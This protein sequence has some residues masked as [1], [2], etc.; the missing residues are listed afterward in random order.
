M[1]LVGVS[2]GVATGKSSVSRALAA[3]AVPVVDA[4]A[5]ARDVVAP[6]TPLLAR[7]LAAFP[8]DARTLPDGSLDRRALG[9]AVFADAGKRR[10]L[11]ALLHPAIARELVSRLRAAFASG[12]H[13]VALDAPLLY[14]SRSLLRLCDATCVVACSPDTQL[15]RL[16]ARDPDLSE[17]DARRRIAA[18][19]P[20]ADKVRQA[21]YVVDNNGSEEEMMQ[22]VR[23]LV[24]QWRAAA[25]TPAWRVCLR[26]AAAATL[27][28]PDLRPAL[29]ALLALSVT[30]AAGAVALRGN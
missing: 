4:D 20:L 25:G 16:R 29:A 23:A 27:L 1:L 5:V 22:Q 17:E 7:V 15:A 24:T 19:L 28:H 9:A 11:N 14:E 8:H 30:A 18:Q 12:A 2:G 21:T 26:L 6:G 10:R 13:V 3:L